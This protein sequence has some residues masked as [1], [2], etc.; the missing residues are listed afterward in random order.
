MRAKDEGSEMRTRARVLIGSTNTRGLLLLMVVAAMNLLVG[1]CS[2]ATDSESTPEA[3]EEDV[4][5]ETLFDRPTRPSLRVLVGSNANSW[6]TVYFPVLRESAGAGGPNAGL[7]RTPSQGQSGTMQ[8]RS[9]V[10]EPLPGFDAGYWPLLA[11]AAECGVYSAE[12]GMELDPHGYNLEPSAPTTSNWL[13][14]PAPPLNCDEITHRVSVLTC[15]AGKLEELATALTPI[16]WERAD[17][18]SEDAIPGWDMP[19]GPWIIPP[20]APESRVV[21]RGLARLTLAYV[22]KALS[23]DVGVGDLGKS[24]ATLYSNVIDQPSLVSDAAFSL[25]IFGAEVNQSPGYLALS[26]WADGVLTVAN[27]DEMAADRLRVLTHALRGG[28]RIL[29]TN[30]AGSVDDDL[31]QAAKKRGRATDLV[32]SNAAAWGLRADGTMPEQESKKYGTYGH[33]LRVLTGRLEMGSAAPDPQCNGISAVD[34]VQKANGPSTAARVTFPSVTTPDE[35]TARCTVEG[36]G[37]IVANP[38]EV[39]ISDA[40]QALAAQA[41]LKAA[42]AAGVDPNDSSAVDTF[43]NSDAAAAIED[44]FADMPDGALRTALIATT[45]E[46]AMLTDQAPANVASVNCST[47][48]LTCAENMSSD[49]ALVGGTVLESAIPK[50]DLTIDSKARSAAMVAAGQCSTTFGGNIGDL[51]KPDEENEPNTY[52]NPFALAQR[53]GRHL[54]QIRELA[55]DSQSTEVDVEGVEVAARA[56]VA[57]IDAWAGRKQVT[58][59]ADSDVTAPANIG[60][61]T[62][63]IGGL[64]LDELGITKEMDDSLAGEVRDALIAD[65]FTVVYGPPATADCVAGLRKSCASTVLA[66]RQNSPFSSEVHDLRTDAVSRRE[67]GMDG[68]A[69]S[70]RFAAADL[71][72]AGIDIPFGDTSGNLLYVIQ[73]HDPDAS[74]SQGKVVAAFNVP[75]AESTADTATVSP[76]LDMF[77]NQVTGIS[78][79]WSVEGCNVGTVHP[80]LSRTHCAG[81]SRNQMVP[82]E[83]ELMETV[84]GD[85]LE[86][87]WRYWVNRAKESAAQTDLLARQMIEEGLQ[88]DMRREAAQEQLAQI[89][90]SYTA[91][92][93][94][95][96]DDFGR[97]KSPEEGTSV[98]SCIDEKRHP[99]V[100]LTTMPEDGTSADWVR[101][102]ILRCVDGAGQPDVGA[103]NPLCKAADSLFLDNA[104]LNLAERESVDSGESVECGWAATSV[105]SLTTGFQPPNLLLGANG[106]DGWASDGALNLMVEGMQI[107]VDFDQ[108]WR[109]NN[110]GRLLMDSSPDSMV[111]PGCLAVG[112]APCDPALTVQIMNFSRGFRSAEKTVLMEPNGCYTG[113][114]CAAPDCPANARLVRET[115]DGGKVCALPVDTNELR[116]ILWRVEGAAWYLASSV[117]RAPAGLILSPI[118]IANFSNTSVWANSPRVAPAYTVYRHSGFNASGYLDGYVEDANHLGQVTSIGSFRWSDNGEVPSWV[119]APYMKESQDSGSYMHVRFPSPE[120]SL[121]SSTGVPSGVLYYTQPHGTELA[122]IQ[123]DN[124]FAGDPLSGLTSD[125]EL[126]SAIL[127]QVVGN[128]LRKS[129]GGS[130]GSQATWADQTCDPWNNCYVSDYYESPFMKVCGMV[131]TESC[132]TGTP[133][134]GG[135][136][137]LRNRVVTASNTYPPIGACGGAARLGQAVLLACESSSRAG[138]TVNEAPAINSLYDFHVVESWAREQAVRARVLL[139]QLYLE[140]LPSRVVVDLRSGTVGSGSKDGSHGTAVARLAPGLRAIV[141]SWIAVENS[142]NALADAVKVARERINLIKIQGESRDKELAIR[143]LQVT[144]GMIAQVSGTITSITN[145]TN[146]VQAAGAAINACLSGAQLYNLGQQEALLEDLDEENEDQVQAETALA[147]LE[148]AQTTREQYTE[149][150]VSL[151]QVA[152]STADVMALAQEIRQAERDAQYAAAKA[153]GEPFVVIDGEPVAIPVNAVLNRQYQL[154]KQ[155]YERSLADS[156]YLAFMA[157]LAIERRIGRRLEDLDA[158]LGPMEAPSVWADDVCNMSGVDYEALREVDTDI[159]LYIIPLVTDP[160]AGQQIEINFAVLDRLMRDVSPFIG[161][162]VSKLELFVDAYNVAYPFQQGDD[163]AVLSIRDDVLGPRESCVVPSSNL[164]LFSDQLQIA[165][166]T[167]SEGGY[168]GWARSSCETGETRCVE[169]MAGAALGT[170]AGVTPATYAPVPPGGVGATGATWLREMPE[171]EANP[172][173]GPTAEVHGVSQTIWLESAG[174]YLLSWWD[175]GRRRTDV[176]AFMDATDPQVEYRVDVLD[177][178]SNAVATFT[179]YPFRPNPATSPEAAWSDR[180]QLVFEV[181][182]AG[183]YTVAFA[184]SL[185]IDELGSVVVANVQL[186]AVGSASTTASLYSSNGASAETIGSCGSLPPGELRAAFQRACTPEGD[187]YYELTEPLSIDAEMLA[188]QNGYLGGNFARGNYNFRHITVALN[189]AG[190]GLVDCEANPTASCYGDGTIRYTLEHD[191]YSAEVVAGVWQ[192]ELEKHHFNFGSGAIRHGQALAAER[193][194]TSPISSADTALLSQPGILKTEF[195]GRPLSGIYR[196]RIWETPGLMWDRL[197]DVQLVLKYRYWSAVQDSP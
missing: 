34:L 151:N 11:A 55:A 171:S 110:S 25:A 41:T 104:A 191:A 187:C 47:A 68:F 15:M 131:E 23:Q 53:F 180:H 95:E 16:R 1:A 49:L 135:G 63:Y 99:V 190:T 169:A 106:I 35:Q 127:G 186:E 6:K 94:L 121:S 146:Y 118:P 159:S 9:L 70:V 78:V 64:T 60:N 83:N 185:G 17:T 12:S 4:E 134:G 18:L 27:A 74:T 147:V 33:A 115:K 5:Q 3:T 54:T 152:S 88:Q 120:L 117:H 30:I 178:S 196:L 82:L 130:G 10:D 19:D 73:K 29:E 113:Q 13:V 162:Y 79:D 166:D 164:L 140:Q 76:K 150:R 100:Y 89:C 57:E 122:G 139:G 128:P 116:E 112:A 193:F 45:H 101:T 149:L 156:K 126:A 181:A 26:E 175:Q 72:V 172:W 38:E 179:G 65:Q 108:S 90:G 85:E 153:K 67:M 66:L 75:A 48:G 170:P 46:Y 24:C 87:S 183:Y 62:V 111:F 32:E 197:E 125:Q 133:R 160:D 103:S 145:V 97:V 141:N 123:C 28:S 157:R 69:I 44:Q 142:L 165:Q 148:L 102:N 98:A 167:D 92:D 2:S 59:V 119:M 173:D 93:Q 86:K 158:P 143:Q 39:D 91:A 137:T 56:A 124:Q 52:S 81:V 36:M 194:I 14:F 80:G 195:L 42:V 58:L 174:T 144:A 168:I 132:T 154:T 182:E 96:F 21:V 84:T 138:F 105:Q 184:P 40:R 163:T 107:E 188:T 177:D 20:L 50:G 136:E 51:W 109:V 77:I 155:R 71:T 61:I 192:G 7:W 129:G 22:A 189:L 114:G 43:E 8:T 161:D 176:G 31:G 37:F